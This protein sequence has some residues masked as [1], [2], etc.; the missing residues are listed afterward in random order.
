MANRQLFQSITSVLPRATVVNEAGGPAY[1]LSAK[2]A[3]AQMAATG[4][5]G[6][7][8]Y[9]SAQ[10]Q[11]DE[12][13][14]L[15][16]EIDDNEFLA[17]LA[18]YSRERAYMKDMPAALLV[19]LSMRDTKLMH[20][21]F[22]RVADNGR[23]LR[24]VFQMIRSGQFGRKGLSSSLQRAFQRW[25]NDASVGKL[26]SASI[27]NDPSLRD[28]LR[29]AR[30]APKDDARRALFGW[31]TDKPVEKWAP[32]KADHLP[33]TVQSLV[34][35][36]AAD[37]AEAQ[38]LIAGDSLSKVRWDLLA[39]A[40]KGPLVWKAIARQMGPQALRMNLN[41]LLRHDVFHSGSVVSTESDTKSRSGRTCHYDNAMIDY[42]AGQLA[43]RD[44]IARSRQFPYQFLAAY[45]NASDEVP[46]KIKTALHDAAE[47]ACGNVRALPGPVI[48]GLDTSGS[49][50][51]AVTG[52]RAGRS[53]RGGGT[54]KMRCVD[55]AA[56]FAAAILRRNPDSVVIPFDTQAYKAKV[57]PSDTI[58]SLS[59]RLSKYGGGGTDCSL[60]FVEANTRY[61]KQAFAGIVLVSDN[62]SWITS[63]RPHYNR[64]SGYGQNGSTGVMTQWEKFKKTQRGL[65]VADPK[66]VCI[67]I[68]PYGTS[69]APERDDILN[70]GGFSDAVFNVVSSFLE[71]DASRFVR[72]V[73]SVEL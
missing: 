13:R 41:T 1:K 18:V 14:K 60:P 6:N 44:A 68:Q 40:A 22:D 64:Y 27:G 70:I 58:L 30:P 28:I 72:E 20:Q 17:K 9:A 50:G 15:I 57:D 55:V 71:N 62:E 19:V 46:N 59:A 33:S 63:G 16:D 38:T 52:N 10:N 61:A 69:Q 43:D 4:T 35:Y 32:A 34:A 5:F 3:I 49:M 24:T 67:D 8:Y 65:G 56:L 45:M 42:V 7:V 47:I 26:L 48:I 51:C 23:V 39:D 2:H 54:S 37:T 11:L 66:L 12:M 36:R 53:G 31:L 21:V 25:L 73:E 29:M